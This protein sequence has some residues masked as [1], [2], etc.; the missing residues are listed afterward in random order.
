MT[1]LQL[2]ALRIVLGLHV[3]SLAEIRD[4]RDS[5]YLGWVRGSE[6]RILPSSEGPIGDGWNLVDVSTF[7]AETWQV[8]RDGELVPGEHDTSENAIRA[9]WADASG[10]GQV[11]GPQ[12]FAVMAR[13]PRGYVVVRVAGPD[14][15]LNRIISW[16]AVLTAR[17]LKPEREATR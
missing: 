16:H 13:P 10:H 15:G 5:G 6:R 2:L 12:T 3:P 9:A 11:S 4:L 7:G 17:G 14:I 8:E 1:A